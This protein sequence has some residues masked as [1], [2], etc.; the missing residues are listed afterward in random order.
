M[1]NKLLIKTFEPRKENML[2]ILHVLQNNNP[3]NFLTSD[4]IK[5]V[6][7]YLNIT[8]SSVYGVAKYYTMF[9]L[10]PRGKYVI[11][12]CKSPMCHM[13]G[14][15]E[16]LQEIENSLEIKPGET[17]PDK[18]F[19]VEETECL[20]RCAKSPVLMIN[21]KTFTALDKEKIKNILQTIRFDEQNIK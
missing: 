14:N 10:K 15:K 16:I 9:S 2:N 1:D 19:S 18:L 11:R 12:V 13:I 5:L 8:Y 17:S 21:D 3:Q 20:G 4:D 6:A 7:N